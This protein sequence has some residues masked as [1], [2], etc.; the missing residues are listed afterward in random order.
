[1][2]YQCLECKETFVHTATL[3]TDISEKEI[4]EYSVCPFCKSRHYDE[5]KLEEQPITSVV[6][7]PLEDVDAKLKEGYQVHEL[8]AKTATLTKREAKTI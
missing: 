6:S 5:L 2:K 4:I 8:Y 7:V 3:T 1:M